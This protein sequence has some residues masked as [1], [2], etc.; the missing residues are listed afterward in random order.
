MHLI[1]RL[2]FG[3]LEMLLV[4]LIN[5]LPLDKYRHVIVC[6]TNST[7]FAKKITRED[8]KIYSL[9]KA[10]GLGFKT[11]AQFWRL[12]RQLRP[13]ILHTY[14]LP[15]I[16]YSLTACL[17]G[18]PIR[19]HAEH[20]RD[21][22]DPEGKIW[23]YNALRKLL[24]PLID[25]FIP[26]S[27]DLEQWLRTR[28]GVLSNKICLINN[29]VD[30]QRF[31]CREK[32]DLIRKSDALFS[33]DHFVIGT[34]GRLQ[35]VK[36][37]LALIDAFLLLRTRFPL[38]AALARLMIVGD[39]P[40]LETLKNRIRQEGLTEFI[41]LP[42]AR[43]DIPE[44][45]RGLSLFAMSSL[46]EGTPVVLLEAMAS[47]LPVVATRVGGIPDLVVH[48]Q[49]GYLVESTNVEALAA[50]MGRY[51]TDPALVQQHGKAGRKRV[52]EVYGL[53]T[54]LKGYLD[55]YDRLCMQKLT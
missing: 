20:G 47:G 48:E 36:N 17:A 27:R 19:V 45:L 9:H 15:T 6:L 43:N 3:G 24:R 49:T 52:E 2:D 38:E 35:E 30:L 41:K 23:K 1:F 10:A 26:V 40:L 5:R 12:C 31:T 29:G 28:I 32:N 53:D 33:E 34:V 55:L 13:A 4:E 44:L 46:A 54:M 39:G 21:I 8:V 11:H 16:E 14:N 25:C 42:G 51:L 37:H 22:S 18:V 7:E 50:A